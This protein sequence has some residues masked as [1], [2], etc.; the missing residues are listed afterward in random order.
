MH[1]T[2]QFELTDQQ[3][4][5][6]A[7]DAPGMIRVTQQFDRPVEASI[8]AAVQRELVPML[9]PSLR[10]QKI[11]ITGSSRG[12]ANLAEVVRHAVSAL[13]AV[14][15]EPFVVPGMGSHGGATATG[16][17]NVLRDTNGITSDSVGCP[18]VSS[19]DVVQIGTTASGF[20]VYQD[21]L[22]HDADGVLV[23]NRVKP[24]TSFTERVESGLC[25]MLVI[26]LGK[27]A[28]AS[29]IHQQSLRI[30][31]GQLILDASRI[32]VEASR[33][34]LIGGLGL[35]ENAFKETAVIRGV[36]MG[37]FDAL[38]EAEGELLKMAYDLLPRIPFDDIDA[39]VVDRIGKNISG[40]GMDSNVIG[41]KPG[42]ASPKI[43]AI[44]VR[45]LTDETHGNATGIGYADLMPRSLVEQID[46]N[47][48]YMN[49]FTAKRPAVGKLP[50]LMETELQALQVLMSFRRH[51]DPASVRLVWISSTA[52]LDTMWVST[53]LADEARTNARLALHGS[54]HQVVFDEA[55][56]MAL[57]TS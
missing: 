47:S 12:I 25:K 30:P 48:T 11:A 52:Q 43:G 57:A 35:V 19:M 46:L 6:G 29:R 26:G 20:P 3:A 24:H 37:S 2:T 44:Y 41:V 39:L 7:A 32:I 9:D 45:G 40:S 51:E 56:H 16:Q 13:R 55:G 50:M 38:V 36:P 23:I 21:K 28:G 4:G 54:A 53:A 49:A 15:A 17:E 5:T 10:G 8:E 34:R 1:N 42:L 27:Q 33:P 18:V 22:C 31:M 14:G